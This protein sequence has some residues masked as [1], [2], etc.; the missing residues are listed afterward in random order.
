[1]HKRFDVISFIDENEYTYQI[2]LK[3]GAKRKKKKEEK[4]KRMKKK[5]KKVNVSVFRVIDTEVA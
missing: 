1:M 3:E 5:V 2:S 4:E